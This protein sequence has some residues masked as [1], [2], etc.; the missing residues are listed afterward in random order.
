MFTAKRSNSTLGS[1]F[2]LLELVFHLTARRIR[3]SSG[4]AI[5][6]LLSNMVQAVVMLA[7]MYVFMNIV[8]LRRTVVRGDYVLYLYSGI[9]LFMT[10]NKTMAAVSGS[11]GPTSSMMKHAPMT[12]AAAILSSALA[13][14]YNQ[15]L[16]LVVVLY[17][18]HAIVT[19]IEID[20]WQG[21][22]GM[23]LLAWFVGMTVGLIFL[24]VAPWAPGLI[25]IVRLV[26]M[27]ANFIASGK[28]F[29]ANS[30]P[31]KMLA[32]FSWNPLFHLI[33]QSRGFTFINYNPHFT[34]WRYALYVGL[35]L[36]ML[37][38]LGE[39]YTRQHASVSWGKGGVL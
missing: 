31:P 12:T 11:G 23:L 33:D 25:G 28:M 18:Y 16:T 10:Y 37:G 13:V 5:V 14:L 22:F 19:P 27:R 15:V 32:L 3:G 29:L 34:D 20:N 30:L 1:T 17:L 39:F 36:L 35:A 9:F 6:G 8:G 26:Y 2:S 24:A 7:V 4:N 38:L 21:A